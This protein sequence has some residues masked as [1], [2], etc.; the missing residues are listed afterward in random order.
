MA[1]LSPQRCSV[2]EHRHRFTSFASV[3]SDAMVPGGVSVSGIHVDAARSRTAIS[4]GPSRCGAR[5]LCRL[6]T[7][8]SGRRNGGSDERVAGI[9]GQHRLDECGERHD[10]AFHRSTEVNPLLIRVSSIT[11]LSSISPSGSTAS[12]PPLLHADSR[13]QLRLRSGGSD[14]V[15]GATSQ[16]A[17]SAIQNFLN[18]DGEE[19]HNVAL[20][21][22]EQI[23]PLTSDC[24]YGTK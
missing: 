6:S 15:R 18:G 24:R 21:Y 1:A 16:Q 17:G 14:S 2:R 23:S 20:P 13:K 9:S 12:E 22:R 5:R 3:L 7:H 11:S 8:Q 10:P 19:L 4:T